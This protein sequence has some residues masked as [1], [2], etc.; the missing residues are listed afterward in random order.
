MRC[1]SVWGAWRIVCCKHT[2]NQ[3]DPVGERLRVATSHCCRDSVFSFSPVGCASI[4]Y[5]T[6][7]TAPVPSWWFAVRRT[8]LVR[9]TTATCN[10]SLHTPLLEAFAGFSR[11]QRS[12]LRDNEGMQGRGSPRPSRPERLAHGSFPAE[13]RRL[14]CAFQL[15]ATSYDVLYLRRRRGIPRHFWL[16]R[17]PL[18]ARCVLGPTNSG[19]PTQSLFLS[20][21]RRTTSFPPRRLNHCPLSSLTGRIFA[22]W[23]S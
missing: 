22:A 10:I 18:L 6:E 4:A 23:C 11:A 7:G 19:K 17:A 13:R 15:C 5:F 8:R 12:V 2:T 20:R 1:S 14:E 3:N 16:A 21:R 9:P